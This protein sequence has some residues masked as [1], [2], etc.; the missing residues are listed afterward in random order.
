MKILGLIAGAAMLLGAQS[1]YAVSIT[2]GGFDAPPAATDPFNYIPAGGPE[3][4][5]WT[6]GGNGVD[7]I[8]NAWQPQNG[9]NSLDLSGQFGSGHGSISQQLSGLTIGQEYKISFYMSGNIGSGQDTKSLD[10]GLYDDA[11]LSLASFEDGAGYIYNTLLNN[12]SNLDMKWALETFTFVAS[13]SAYYLAFFDTSASGSNSGA[14]IDNIS[15]ASTAVTPIPPAILLFASA[16]G[17]M[18][19]FGYRRKKQAA[20]A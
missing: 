20:E 5:G 1:A 16:L 3:L 8:G 4:T 6:V 10:L 18:G 7:H 13:Q 14:A 15:I 2:N 11:S 19:F 9:A 12:N 17:G